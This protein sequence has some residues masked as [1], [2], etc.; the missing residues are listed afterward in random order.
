MRIDKFI[1][2][3]SEL[4]RSQI[5][6]LIKSNEIFCNDQLVTSTSL[7][8]SASDS[9]RINHIKIEKHN[10]IYLMLYKPEGVISATTDASQPTVIDLIQLP[11][12]TKLQIV[13]RLDKD[14]TGLLLLTDDGDW[15]HQLTSPK[16]SHC[17][18]YVVT[19][20]EP[21]SLSTVDMFAEGILLN[22]EL[23]KTLPAQLNI[24][25][26]RCA[27]LQ[28]TEGKY[29]QV[30]RMFAAVGN[31][32]IKLHRSEI[33][34]LKLDDSLKPGEYRELTQQEKEFSLAAKDSPCALGASH[35][36]SC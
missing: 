20:A 12:K 23:K 3:N 31:H 10:P 35:A 8:I 7:S 32:V 13:G 16:K 26:E 22:S 30:K 25:S 21:I 11:N 15:N 14:T 36:R 4:S 34:L 24:I 6:A 28:L 27:E 1:G 17:K 29:H 5:H 18:T 19:T 33:G 2:N 9:I